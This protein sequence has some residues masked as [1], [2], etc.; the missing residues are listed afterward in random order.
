MS[1]TASPSFA[2][3]SVSGYVYVQE[4]GDEAVRVKGLG[5]ARATA[6]ERS[7]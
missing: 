6:K 3:I 5:H 7:A 2:R 1:A 4:F